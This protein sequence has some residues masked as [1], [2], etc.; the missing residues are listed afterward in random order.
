MSDFIHSVAL[1]SLFDDIKLLIVI[2]LIIALWCEVL[3]KLTQSTVAVLENF[4][5]AEHVRAYKSFRCFPFLGSKSKMSLALQRLAHTV[6]RGRV[7]VG[8]CGYTCTH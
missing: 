7:C 8:V 3:M 2:Y 1:Q 4:L 6:V 5:H